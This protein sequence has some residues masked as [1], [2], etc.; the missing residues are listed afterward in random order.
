MNSRYN[1]QAIREKQLSSG[2]LC[3][4]LMNNN[5]KNNPEKDIH[6]IWHNA[7]SATMIMTLGSLGVFLLVFLAVFFLTRNRMEASLVIPVALFVSM[8]FMFVTQ[9][10]LRMICTR[11]KEKPHA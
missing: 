5:Q 11:K 10:V 7:A 6:T 2:Q 4:N 1:R 9:I 3:D 8:F